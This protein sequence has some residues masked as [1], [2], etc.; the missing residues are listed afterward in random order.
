VLIRQMS[1]L[2]CLIIFTSGFTGHGE[3][4]I[5]GDLALFSLMLQHNLNLDVMESVI[6]ILRSGFDFSTLRNSKHWLQRLGK[7]ASFNVKTCCQ[8]C[9]HLDVQM[10]FG[11]G[12]SATISTQVNQNETSASTGEKVS[13]S[14]LKPFLR[15][16]FWASGVQVHHMSHLRAPGSPDLNFSNQ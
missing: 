9:S 6:S 8:R 2:H 11:N 14:T 3:G 16:L 13:S 15:E 4:N 5:D 12:Q 7:G 10:V 1:F